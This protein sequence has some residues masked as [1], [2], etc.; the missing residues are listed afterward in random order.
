[1]TVLRYATVSWT[2][3]ELAAKAAQALSTVALVQGSG[4]VREVP[5]V[6]AIRYYT[7]TGLL[8]RPLAFEGRTALYGR[9]HLLQLV[10]IKRLQA[11]GT[12]LAEVQQRLH[13]LTDAA[14]QKLAGPLD[15]PPAKPPPA[16]RREFWKQSPGTATLA[17]GISLSFP[18]TRGLEPEDLEALK[19]AAA[20]LLKVLQSRWLIKGE[21]T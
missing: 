10:A 7:T 14:L 11:S 8:D 21:R 18:A 9:R 5:D 17:P 16:A 3:E 4:R 2:I 1:M 20:P 13:G 12:P 19:A 15:G 6:R